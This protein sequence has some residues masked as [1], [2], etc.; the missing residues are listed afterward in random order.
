MKQYSQAGKE[1]RRFLQTVNQGGYAN[2][3]YKRVRQWQAQG[4]I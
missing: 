3:A 2:H 4:L 1:Y